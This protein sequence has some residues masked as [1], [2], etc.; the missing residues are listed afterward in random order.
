MRSLARVVY[1]C[2]DGSSETLALARAGTLRGRAAC[3][4]DG[5]GRADRDGRP[6]LAAGGLVSPGVAAGAA[7]DLGY[8]ADPA[9]GLAGQ[10]DPV[11]LGVHQVI[12]GCLSSPAATRRD[13]SCS[14]RDHRHPGPVHRRRDG[15]RCR[16]RRP[17]ARGPTRRNPRPD[18]P[19]PGRGRPRAVP[20]RRRPVDDS[21]R[22]R[23]RRRRRPA[24][25]PPAPVQPRR[26]HPRGALG[27]RPSPHR[28]P[29]DVAV[30]LNA[31]REA[32]AV[33]AV[34]IL[35]ARKPRPSRRP[36]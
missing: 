7:G 13:R 16:R 22:T 6:G 18:Q 31:L 36:R 1:L 33:D 12:G 8:I 28:G 2:G 17:G 4:V 24:R 27:R 32:G 29:G 5:A 11:E 30:L 9:P 21:R 10:W 14:R 20:P 25:H 23:R 3:R 15:H 35:L 26:H 19:R 34:A